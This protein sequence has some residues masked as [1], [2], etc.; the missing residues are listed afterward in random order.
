MQPIPNSSS[1]C[2]VNHCHRSPSSPARCEK[3]ARRTAVDR[4]GS[5]RCPAQC[6]SDGQCPNPPESPAGAEG[7][8]ATFEWSPIRRPD[9]GPKP[10]SAAVRCL[11]RRSLR[12]LV[13]QP[14]PLGSRRAPPLATCRAPAGS[15]LVNGGRTAR[16]RPGNRSE[17]NFGFVRSGDFVRTSGRFG[18]YRSHGLHL[19]SVPGPTADQTV[20]ACQ[21]NLHAGGGIPRGKGQG[22]ARV[23]S[24]GF[25]DVNPS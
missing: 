8:R 15:C 13:Q 5:A 1:V 25:C 23:S 3:L 7:H 11:A 19:E 10:G 16:H 21:P 6:P 22:S 4:S 18:A 12:V 17:V 24:F 14:R 9:P 20:F 2:P